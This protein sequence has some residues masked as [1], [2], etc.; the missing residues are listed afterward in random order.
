MVVAFE[1]SRTMPS[2][3]IGVAHRAI[4]GG[5]R[6]VHEMQ[7]LTPIAKV[8]VKDCRSVATGTSHPDRRRMLQA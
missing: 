1:V 2:L 6:L 4:F 5:Q 3:E 7:P 8:E